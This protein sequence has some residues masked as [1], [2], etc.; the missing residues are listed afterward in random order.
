MKSCTDVN[1]TI[2]AQFPGVNSP[3]WSDKIKNEFWRNVKP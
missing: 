1:N 3:K 2:F